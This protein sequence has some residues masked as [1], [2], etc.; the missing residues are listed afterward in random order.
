MPRGRA[1]AVRAACQ[2]LAGCETAPG[3]GA[4]AGRALQLRALGLGTANWLRDRDGRRSGR[5]M[6]VGEGRHGGCSRMKS[7]GP[8]RICLSPLAFGWTSEGTTMAEVSPGV[9]VG[10]PL[11]PGPLAGRPCAAAQQSWASG[12]TSP[13]SSIASGQHRAACRTMTALERAGGATGGPADAH[14]ALGGAAG[15]QQAGAARQ[16][17]AGGGHRRRA[18]PRRASSQPRVER[19]GSCGARHWAASR[20]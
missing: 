17:A 18:P 13:H 16:L 9:R 14:T 20:R 10:P 7:A 12:G 15:G 19:A 8:A 2:G 3:G 1:G 5:F 11:G 4:R 6:P